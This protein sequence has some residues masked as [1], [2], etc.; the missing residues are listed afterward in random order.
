MVTI[1]IGLYFKCIS[2]LCLIKKIALGEIAL[3]QL[4]SWWR[5]VLVSKKKPSD[6]SN[7][8]IQEPDSMTYGKNLHRITN[9]YILIYN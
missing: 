3:I 5:L 7:I 8:G 6:N 1:T 9:I 2:A 4:R